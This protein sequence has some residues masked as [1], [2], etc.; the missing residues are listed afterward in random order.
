MAKPNQRKRAII[1]GD[2]FAVP[3]QGGRFAVCRVLKVRDK[4]D[5]LVANSS[6]IGRQ[7]PNA[8]DPALQ[9][10]LRL[11]HHNWSGKPSAAWV[12]GKPPKGF[13]SIGVIPV[14]PGEDAIEERGMG[15]WEF[16]RFQPLAQWYWDHP[17]D[18]PPAPPKPE[19][20]FI[21][22]RFN[23]DEI[24]RFESA[25]MWAYA[26][27]PGATLW[28]EISADPTAV[29]RCKDSA[30]MGMS[31]NAEVG[32]DLPELDADKLVGRELV[33][34]GVKSRDEDSCRS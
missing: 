32:I 4:M 25:V 22:H 28:F 27:G 16:F 29:Q 18:V 33:I 3:L 34:Q 31:P 21:L 9:S 20:R 17:E 19:G 24:Y 14:K 2:A 26:N 12:S 30:E 15:A 10:V 8:K 5:L 23:G 13:I 1:A 6:W 11:T 7:V